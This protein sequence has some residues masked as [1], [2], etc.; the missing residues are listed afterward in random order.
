MNR[1]M[2]VS[3]FFFQKKNQ[4]YSYILRENGKLIWKL[5]KESLDDK[6]VELNKTIDWLS[7][8]HM[9]ID[10]HRGEYLYKVT[11]LLILLLKYIYFTNRDYF[12]IEDNIYEQFD[13]RFNDED[14]LNFRKK[15]TAIFY[16]IFYLKSKIY[17]IV[18]DSKNN[19]KNAV[20]KIVKK[21]KFYLEI[22][23]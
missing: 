10:C 13:K 2:I 15:R 7:F 6:I 23:Y 16:L 19:L 12:E 1:Y 9:D 20:R 17:E 11:I 21:N 18:N 8:F 14:T 4:G 3:D 5:L 22:T